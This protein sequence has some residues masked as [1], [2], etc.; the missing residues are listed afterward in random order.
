MTNLAMAGLE[1]EYLRVYACSSV[2]CLGGLSH[3]KIRFC[4]SILKLHTHIQVRHEF[5]IT[6]FG[7]FARILLHAWNIGLPRRRVKK[8]LTS[9]SI[10]PKGPL[11][12]SLVKVS[13]LWLFLFHSGFFPYFF[14]IYTFRNHMWIWMDLFENTLAILPDRPTTMLY[15]HWLTASAAILDALKF[16]GIQYGNFWACKI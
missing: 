3:L 14:F 15:T 12:H 5:A 8:N 11:R 10:H 7:H 9:E 1:K 4:V 6:K 2:S 13:I 16:R